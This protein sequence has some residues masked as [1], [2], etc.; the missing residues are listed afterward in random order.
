MQDACTFSGDDRITDL[1]PAQRKIYA[2]GILPSRV[3]RLTGLSES[4]VSR[5]LRG[6][7][8]NPEAQER[9]ARA[10]GMEPRTLFGRLLAESLR[11]E[12]ANHAA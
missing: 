2:K 9:I 8:R 5:T 4:T 12:G 1:S 3:A 10:V 7:N 6:L 11:D